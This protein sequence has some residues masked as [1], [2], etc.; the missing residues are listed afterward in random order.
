MATQTKT[1]GIDLA[2]RCSENVAVQFRGLD[3]K[4]AWPMAHVAQSGL[5]LVLMAHVLVVG[6]SGSLLLRQEGRT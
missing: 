3:F 4:S 6:L 5:W 2:V 1:P